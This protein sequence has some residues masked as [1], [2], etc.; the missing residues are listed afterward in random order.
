MDQR[1]WQHASFGAQHG[2][3]S[4]R[5][6]QSTAHKVVPAIFRSP[7]LCFLGDHEWTAPSARLASLAG[8][9]VGVRT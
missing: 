6:A 3:R 7:H 5:C 1:F 8:T 2:L 9:G 4:T